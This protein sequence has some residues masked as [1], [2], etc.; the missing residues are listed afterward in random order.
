MGA[1][2]REPRAKGQDRRG[3]IEGLDLGLLV[4]T[5]HEGAFG[6]VDVEP[7]DV[8]DLVDEERVRRE[9]EGFGQMGL[10]P[11]RPPDP[12]D[13]RLAHPRGLGHR[14][15]RP[16]GG[17]DRCLFQRFH[18]HGLDG[19]VAHG[20]RC[21]GSGFIVESFEPSGDEPRPPFPHRGPADPEF[22]CHRRVAFALG[23]RQD[24]ATTQGQRLC[25]FRTSSPALEGGTLLW[26]QLQGFEK[27]TGHCA[28]HRRLQRR[29]RP[30]GGA[31]SYLNNYF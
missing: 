12:T 18:D 31:N 13:R 8:A 16:V 29:E 11:E 9:L 21:T 27:R 17:V 23:A 14:P 22:F 28:S 25:A 26:G 19:V 6:R 24:D 3:P 2:F 4:D 15:R 5:Q 20:A 10:E 30:R 7:D 1:S